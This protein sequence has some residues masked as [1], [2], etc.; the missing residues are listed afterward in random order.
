M[1]SA[2]QWTLY[3]DILPIVIPKSQTVLAAEGLALSSLLVFAG[4][5]ESEMGAKPG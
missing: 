5:L 3:G 1:T 2:S 4:I